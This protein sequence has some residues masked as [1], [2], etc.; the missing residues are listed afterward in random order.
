MERDEVSV[1]RTTIE[2]T[3]AILRGSLRSPSW[4]YGPT[5]WSYTRELE[6]MALM[7]S[8]HILR[9]NR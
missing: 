9:R 8:A 4:L 3:F 2:E 6:M 1:R 7:Q 5:P